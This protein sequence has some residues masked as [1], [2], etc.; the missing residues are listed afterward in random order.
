ME[1]V[2]RTTYGP[3]RGEISDGIAS[4]LGIPYA[5]S[6]TGALRFAAPV[7]PEPWTTPHD[8][9]AFGPTPPKPDYATPFDTLLGDPNIPGDDWLNLNVW[10]P[11]ASAPQASGESTG[12]RPV[13]VWIHGGAFQNGNSAVPWYDGRAFARRGVVLVSVNY[14]LGVDGFALIP[15]AQAPANRGMLDQVA[16]LEWVRDNIAA[17]G[18]DPANVT[19]FG[20]SAGAMSVTTLLSM[21]RAAGLF[22]KAIAQSGAAQAAADLADAALV[23][24][25]LAKAVGAPAADAATLS[26]LGID[27]LNA[28]QVSVR[29]ALATG[30]DVARFGVTIVASSMPFI[31]VVDGEVL[32]EHPLAAISA[33]AGA[34]VPLLIGINSEEYRFFSVP[35][36][37]LDQITAEALPLV[38]AAL[39][40]SAEVIDL[41]QANRPD[42][43]PGDIFAA[44]VTDRYFRLPAL[45]L[46]HAH[47]ASA[48]S[49]A[50]TYFYEFRWGNPPMG[51]GHSL[52]IPFVFD[53]LSQAGDDPLIGPNPPQDLAEEMQS[54]WVRFASTGDPG[55][56]AFDE[57]RPVR[58]FDTGTTG[59]DSIE[60]DPRGDERAIWPAG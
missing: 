51:A 26:G 12:A 37:L 55:W 28:A 5:A 31:P 15:D 20:E 14:R 4:Y 53:N 24:A 49:T 39:G 34:D 57:S 35:P 30:P 50:A 8:A 27:A 40:G 29:D 7:P 52:E 1:S 54:A 16:A 13:M 22:T 32:P 59:G 42:G 44:M 60:S 36:G 48:S 23:S 38:V 17:F 9:T 10:T 19:I 47:S 58:I 43:T 2:V 18:G 41:Y 21:P 33:G 11:Q 6:P 25:E 3:V 45:G 46:A 56:V